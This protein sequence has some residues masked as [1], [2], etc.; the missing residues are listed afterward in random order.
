MSNVQYTDTQRTPAQI[1]GLVGDQPQ[2]AP[3]EQLEQT[4]EQIAAPAV[5]Q[6]VEPAQPQQ[7]EPEN[8]FN[9][10]SA[11]NHF[12]AL[13]ADKFRI[14]RERAQLE[15]ERNEALKR[16]QSYES[17][18]QAPEPDEPTIPDEEYMTGKHL[19]AYAKEIKE[20]K[21]QLASNHQQT[22]T[23]VA[24]AQ[25]K[26]QY[27]DFYQIVSEENVALLNTMHPE[28]ANTIRTSTDTYAKAVTAYTMIKRLGIA[29]P[30]DTYVQD[31]ARVKNNLAKPKPSAA[32]T[33]RQSDSPLSNVNAFSQ[34]FNDE[35]KARY[36]KEMQ[37]AIKGV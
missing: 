2:E 23:A 32:V 27:P 11:R 5:E 14:E 19:K 6:A 1:N 25:I 8:A 31:K 12:K 15:Y 18:R 9:S 36:Y 10:Q 20:L 24:E 29:A 4:V 33:P 30:E 22:A 26:A 17:S 34:E 35:A 28:I 16:L 3:Q 13:Q 37:Q 7:P 21:K